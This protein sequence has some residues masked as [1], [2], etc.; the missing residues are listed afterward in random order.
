MKRNTYP[1]KEEV[2]EYYIQQLHTINECVEHFN[3]SKT[4]MYT[5]L[6][7]Y[8][9]KR[10]EED[11]SKV[12]SNAQ[13]KTENKEKIRQT[14]LRK[15]GA[16]N[17]VQADAIVKFYD[18]YFTIYGKQYSVEWLKEN[19]LVKNV[20]KADLSEELGV[21]VGILAKLCSYYGFK[22]TFSQRGEIIKQ[23]T[24]EKYGVD[25]SFQ[26]EKVKE[27]IKKTV[28]EKYGVEN[29]M[30]LPEIQARV[31]ATML[32]KYGV[33]NY[34]QTSEYRQKVIAANLK[35]Y[36]VPYH[37]QKEIHHFDIWIDRDKMVKLIESLA[38]KP[39]VYDLATY[40]NLKDITVVYDRMHDWHLDDLVKWKPCRSHYEDEII[41]FLSSLGITDLSLNNRKVLEGQEIDIFIPDY[42]I[43][44]EFNGDYWHSD[45]F[46]CDHNGR[47]TY[48]QDKS[49]LA[50]KKGVFLFHIFEHEWD[51][52]VDKTN[53]KN[54][55]KTLFSKNDI[56]IAARK[57]QLVELTKAQKKEFLDLNHIQGNDR[58]TKQYGLV[59][60]NE[61][62]ACMTFVHPKNDK[63]TWELSRFCNKHNCVVQGGASKL[64]KHFVKTLKDGDTVSSYNDIT[65]TKGD[66]Y[67][68]LGFECV[69]I[70]QPNYVWINFQIRD[71][72]T[73]YQEQASGE[74]ERMHGKGYHRVCDCGTKTWVYT[75]TSK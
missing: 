16:V 7:K 36:G 9:I 55:L 50:E 70:N 62:V 23:K 67:K 52:P 57:T 39:T 54:R 73:R 34:A 18:T 4:K 6:R 65:K 66:L 56:K 26:I 47:S 49:L 28:L 61:I 25:S 40:F 14:N 58:S 74:V 69:S 63:Y 64:F 10:T 1:S 33:E 72:R 5:C 68:I 3:I 21:G 12:Y 45:L 59:Y 20:A 19:Y 42:R 29:V 2:E 75:K 51:N 35:K 13:S 15:Y 46:C 32:E 30:N 31:K 43:G 11:K 48:H 41:E 37:Q 24:R 53:I 71:I 60:Q 22:K 27:K 44:I 17:K 8:G 38:E